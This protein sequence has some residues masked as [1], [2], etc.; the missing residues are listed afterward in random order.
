MDLRKILIVCWVLLSSGFLHGQSYVN[1]LRGTVKDQITQQPLAY[2]QVILSDSIVASTDDNGE[3][4][5]DGL[6]L[7]KYTLALQ[8][9]GYENLYLRNIQINTGKETIINIVME[10]SIQN[11]QEVVVSA[12]KEKAKPLNEMS[13]ISTRMVSVEETQR[14]AASFND[15]ARMA[16]SFAGVVQTDAGNNHITIRGNAPNGLLWRLE[17]ID[18]P[19][20]NHFAYVSTSGG[21]VSIL[22]G[23]LLSNSDFSTGAFAAEYGNA[24][25]SV[26]DIKLRKGN[27]EKREYTFQIGALGI[28][29]AVEG[30][31]KKG[32]KNSY[33]VNYRYSTLGLLSKAKIIDI[34]GSITTFQDLS[35]NMAFKNKKWGDITLFGLN[36]LSSQTGQDTTFDQHID[37]VSNTLVN[38][39]THSKTFGSNSFLRTAL[40]ISNTQNSIFVNENDSLNSNVS[41]VAYD[42]NHRHDKVTLSSKFQH[43]LSANTALK[44][45]FIHSTLRYKLR[46]V[47]K[48]DFMAPEKTLF[49]QQGATSLSQFFV[50]IQHKISNRLTTNIGLHTMYNWL[51]AKHTIEPRAAIQYGIAPRQTLTL[52]YGLHS[53]LLPLSTYFVQAN[54][55][56]TTT[57]VNKNLGMSKAHHIV[58]GYSIQPHDLLNIKAEV[59][60]QALFNVPQGLV[61]NDNISL[62]N[63]EFGTPDIPLEN[64]GIGKNYGVEITIEKYLNR[65]LYFTFTN[66][67]Y[68]SK[69]KGTN[70][71]W[72]D[73]RFNGNFATTFTGGK[74][75]SISKKKNRTMSINMK[76]IYTG[77][78]RQNP[79]D[80][81]KSIE[82]NSTVYDTS[83]P[84]SL[85][86]KNFLRTD[87]KLAFKRNY[88]HMTTSLVFD[89]QNVGNVQNVNGQYFNPKSK[90]IANYTQV[91][92]LPIISY[93][94]EF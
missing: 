57:L 82:K 37:F 13:L 44:I 29:L 43:K 58:L 93:K 86:M 62:V 90:T 26:F 89:M 12:D 91:G 92:L 11:M 31:F 41:F 67:I 3:F 39:I 77:G 54:V 60:Y 75:F 73:T 23:Q 71:Q 22:S 80:L 5:F 10:E 49:R 40:V 34:G 55:N 70:G 27:N 47:S 38:G 69:F 35:Y 25:S 78:L 88:K 94:I 66:S 2:V 72:Y 74:E 16:N 8:Y 64:K 59:Y 18:I 45:G 81:A 1:T 9:V 79:I 63:L 15:P 68:D 85:R 51:N 42:E 83:N 33:L 19:N 46:Q 28:D 6:K 50:Q 52:G 48:D 7:G 84:Y 20:P 32:S 65:G 61:K 36:G 30:P 4:R 87:V 56:E 17:G 21:G 53:Q 14:Y 24:L 76:V